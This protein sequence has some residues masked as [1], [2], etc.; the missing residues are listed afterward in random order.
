MLVVGWVQIDEVAIES[1]GG[2]QRIGPGGAAGA[3]GDGAVA[4]RSASTA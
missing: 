3:G 4:V 1:G 2:V